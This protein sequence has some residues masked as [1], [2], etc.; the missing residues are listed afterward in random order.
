MVLVCWYFWLQKKGNNQ[1]HIECTQ[2]CQFD[3]FEAKTSP[4]LR[5][6][7]TPCHHSLPFFLSTSSY[8][9][10][11]N[12]YTNI[13]RSISVVVCS[14]V[15]NCINFGDRFFGD[16]VRITFWNIV[17]QSSPFKSVII[18]YQNF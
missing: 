14:D 15:S 12:D 3:V 6:K 5:E 16:N 11:P 4:E 18:V 1:W 17:K 10:F 2:R 13:G 7:Y 8:R 9:H